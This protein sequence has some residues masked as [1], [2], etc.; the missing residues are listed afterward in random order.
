MPWPAHL[1][2]DQVN[3]Q[4]TDDAHPDGITTIGYYAFFTPPGH[5]YLQVEGIPGY[6]EWRSPVVEVITQIVH[7]NVPYTPWVSD[8]DVYSVTVMPAPIK[9]GDGTLWAGVQI[10]PA[11]ITVPVGS[12]VEWTSALSETNTIDDLITWSEN[13]IFQV[14]SERGPLQ[15]TRGFDSGY[16]EPGRV[17]R[18]AFAYPG[19]YT[20]H[21]VRAQRAGDRDLTSGP[22]STCRWCS[23]TEPFTASHPILAR[24]SS[25]MAAPGLFY[26]RLQLRSRATP[27]KNNLR[28]QVLHLLPANSFAGATPLLRLVFC[29]KIIPHS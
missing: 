24:S 5:Y 4:V 23:E 1:Y 11:V 10:D 6:Q 28:R 3:P 25:T 17:Y 2:D 13:P 7:V 21:C 29:A 18:R 12:T 14:L 9:V 8:T 22:R 26:A 16:L 20:I 15:D 19:V 27:T